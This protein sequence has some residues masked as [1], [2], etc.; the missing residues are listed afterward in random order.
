LPASS[1]KDYLWLMFLI[2]GIALLASTALIFF[3]LDDT[4]VLM[5]ACICPMNRAD[6]NASAFAVLKQNKIILVLLSS[7]H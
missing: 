5:E 3:F 1:F 7:W 2:S 4:T 6:D